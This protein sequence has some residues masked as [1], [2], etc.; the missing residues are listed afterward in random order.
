M[1]R[2][3]QVE[4]VGIL[5]QQSFGQRRVDELKR[6]F[7]ELPVDVVQSLAVIDRSACLSP[8]G[9]LFDPAGILTLRAGEL[10]RPVWSATIPCDVLQPPRSTKRVRTPGQARAEVHEALAVNPQPGVYLQYQSDRRLLWRWTL[11]IGGLPV[12]HVAALLEE[13]QNQASDE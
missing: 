6:L 1:D 12:Q 4:V 5:L 9:S 8:F 3:F 10:E 11:N 7:N 2:R 13:L